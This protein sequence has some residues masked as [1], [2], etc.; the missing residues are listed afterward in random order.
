M[1][2]KKYRLKKNKKNGLVAE[3]FF[4]L[5][6]AMNGYKVKRTG[7]GSDFKTKKSKLL[8]SK[9]ESWNLIEV[10]SGNSKLSP[11]QKKTKKKEKK[12][13]VKR[14]KPFF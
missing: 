13:K 9:K 10:K 14:Y 3:R 7:R 1:F 2:G 4:K 8:S 6:S 11:L 12:Y 5:E